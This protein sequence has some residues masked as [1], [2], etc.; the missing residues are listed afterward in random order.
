[1]DLDRLFISTKRVLNYLNIHN[2]QTVTVARNRYG[3]LSPWERDPAL[4]G[5]AVITGRY[6]SCEAD[7]TRILYQMLQ[8]RIEAAVR[9]DEERF[10][11]NLFSF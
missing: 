7:V 5:Q 1:M 10:K 8:C 2:P 11:F 3:C 4:Y 6:R 9:D